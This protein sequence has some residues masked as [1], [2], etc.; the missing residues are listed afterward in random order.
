[1]QNAG[2]YLVVT[3]FKL[4]KFALFRIQRG[5]MKG[6]F[7]S[8]CKSATRWIWCFA[9][10][11]NKCNIID[12]R[13]PYILFINIICILNVWN[14]NSCLFVY[15]FIYFLVEVGE[16]KGEGGLRGKDKVRILRGNVHLYRLECLNL[17]WPPS[18]LLRCL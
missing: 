11:V 15:L 13:M 18:E 12:V 4:W 10:E 5:W 14:A 16:G 8:P 2:K 6:I 1:M 17:K 9:M 3:T 7:L